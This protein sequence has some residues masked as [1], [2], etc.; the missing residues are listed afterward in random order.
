MAVQKFTPNQVREIEAIQ[1]FMRTVEHVRKLVADLE[2]NR[3][4]RP[5]IINNICGTIARELSQMRQRALSAN[6]GTLADVAGSLSVLAARQG[7]GLSFK[8]R[9]LFEGVASLTI[10]LEQSLKAASQVEKATSPPEQ[11]PS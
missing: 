4:A 11:K 1:Q 10:Q 7:S 2:S 8:I 9:A 6:V 3:A 5:V